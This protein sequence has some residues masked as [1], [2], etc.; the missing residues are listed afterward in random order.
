[1]LDI[2]HLVPICFITFI[3]KPILVPGALL[4]GAA[5][6]IWF[7]K[8]VHGMRRHIHRYRF[9]QFFFAFF[10][11]LA[12][13]VLMLG[14]ALP[15]VDDAIFFLTYANFTGIAF[16][17]IVASLIGFPEILNDISEAARLTYSA[18]TLRDV[19]IDEKLR[20]LRRLM[21][22]DR[23]FQNEDLSLSLLASEIGLSAHQLSELI[24]TQFGHGY[25][26]YVREQRVMAAKTLLLEDQESS[27]LSIGLSTGFRSQSNF[28]AA[29][30]EATGQ[31]PGDFRRHTAN[32]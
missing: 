26:R 25:S 24:N 22:K 17:L 13:V 29:F 5:Y 6:S 10:A 30:R 11:T 8:V 2:L 20:H 16:V 21:D 9:E 23:I 3:P 32:R 14:I 15:Y 12:V 27:V 4:L 31:S 19:N 7:V 1:M 18:S 28:Y